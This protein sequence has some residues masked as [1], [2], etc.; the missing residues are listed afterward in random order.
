MLNTL[1]NIKKAFE[2]RL[3]LITPSIATAYEAVSFTPVAEVPYQRVQLVP[4]NPDNPTMGDNYYREVGEFQIF[5]C[6]P[7][8]KGTGEV[9]TRAQLVRS[10]FERGTTLVE[11]STEVNI[12][13]TPQIAGTA[14]VG[15][16]VIVPVI[17]S[18][19]AG[20]FSS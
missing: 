9:L 19:S 17:V 10:Y 7:T 20:V 18:Y 14:T 13:V 16:R 15:D 3:A 11:G 4:R 6:Y 2:K 1:T 5:L 12:I 8:N